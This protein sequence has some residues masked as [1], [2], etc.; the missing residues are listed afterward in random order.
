MTAVWPLSKLSICGRGKLVWSY[1]RRCPQEVR[2]KIAVLLLLAPHE[3]FLLRQHAFRQT[4]ATSA[5]II[6]DVSTSSYARR[7]IV[8]LS[9]L[10]KKSITCGFKQRVRVDNVPL[11]FVGWCVV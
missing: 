9:S 2:S 7:E 3:A 5:L 10:L 6:A 11:V 1:L 4:A 8:E